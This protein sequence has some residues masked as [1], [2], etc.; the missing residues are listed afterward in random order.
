MSADPRVVALQALRQD[1]VRADDPRA[2]CP[3]LTCVAGVPSCLT[4]ASLPEWPWSSFPQ[5]RN[6]RP[7]KEFYADAM[8]ALRLALRSPPP[9]R[10]WPGFVAGDAARQRPSAPSPHLSSWSA[11]SPWH[12]RLSLG[13]GG[14]GQCCAAGCWPS[15]CFPGISWWDVAGGGVS[16][17]PSTPHPPA[18]AFHRHRPGR[19]CL[20]GA[21][22]SACGPHI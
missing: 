4:L 7:P 17:P 12:W 8:G 13:G 1:G 14:A 5:A 3:L 15:G 21:G 9:L 20:G 6:R 2:W 11:P 22:G 18:G 16:C 10:V 19:R